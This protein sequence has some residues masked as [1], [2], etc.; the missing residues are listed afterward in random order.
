MVFAE[1]LRRARKSAG[2]TQ[3]ALAEKL[4]LTAQAVSRW[5]T[6]E[7]YPE[8]TLLP[9]L[10]DI[11]GMTADAL[12]RP[13]V[14]TPEEEQKIAWEA[15]RLAQSGKGEAALRLLKR[16]VE[17]HPASEELR[18][19]LCRSALQIAQQILGPGERKRTPAEG[20][21]AKAEECLRLAEAQGEE[22]LRSK[23][24]W[25]RYTAETVLPEVYYRLG[26]KE[27][28][29]SFLHIPRTPRVYNLDI[30]A[31]GKDRLYLLSH[32]VF[33]G[34][35]DLNNFLISMTL[36][37]PADREP[38]AGQDPA[39]EEKLL[40]Y[41]PLKDEPAWSL[42]LE[43]RYELHR[44]RAEL[45]ERFS[46][47]AGWGDLRRMELHARTEMLKMSVR[48]RDR[49]RTLET[50]EGILSRFADSGLL[51]WEQP[52]IDA[53]QHFRELR[54]ALERQGSPTPEAAAAEALSP[55]ERALV[56]EPVSPHPALKY[57]MQGRI[58]I[59][60]RPLLADA[61]GELRQLLAS[62]DF[63]FLR[64]EESFLSAGQRLDALLGE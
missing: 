46:C 44:L 11:L 53:A 36:F 54:T 60:A 6:G 22:L 18:D 56:T 1:N 24:V 21:R 47:G 49:D 59:R 52:R 39:R 27:K 5:E 51:R 20:E 10:A 28:L 62:P 32:A 13:A 9:R 57:L 7:G 29:L 8:I 64:E 48:L 63:D 55:G 42:S 43:E 25:R 34:L 38:E 2:L 50:L 33:R 3:E 15:L 40:L 26:E 19:Q 30:C 16:N 61:L 37:S 17:A 12:L 14:L 35:L 23:D 4:H 41:E 58:S 45:L 31:A